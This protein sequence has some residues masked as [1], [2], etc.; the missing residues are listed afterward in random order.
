MIH[1]RWVA[2]SAVLALAA[3]GEQQQAQ[4]TPEPKATTTKQMQA[5]A[6]GPEAPQGGEEQPATPDSP[7]A[8]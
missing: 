4:T 1:M 3:C 2:L 8:N 7:P 5:P 6:E